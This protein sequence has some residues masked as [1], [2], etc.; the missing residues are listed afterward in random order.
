MTTHPARIATN[1]STN[2][3]AERRATHPQR[4]EILAIL[5]E[6]RTRID[7]INAPIAG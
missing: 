7:R 1:R 6:A 3:S 2:R 5:T 4:T